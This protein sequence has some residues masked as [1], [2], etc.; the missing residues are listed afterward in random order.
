MDETNGSVRTQDRSIAH[1]L[2]RISLG[3]TML[4][5]GVVRLMAGATTFADGM[6][7]QFAKTPLPAGLVRSFGTALP[8]VETL[9]GILLLVGFELRWTLVAGA[10]FITILIFGSTLHGDFQVVGLQLIYAAVYFLLLFTREYDRYSADG[11]LRR[12]R[13]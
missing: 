9:V 12:K 13:T 6:V 7:Q 11:L 8:F 2:L 1:A 5:H 10:L 3:T 4:L